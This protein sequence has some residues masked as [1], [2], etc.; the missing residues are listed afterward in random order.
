MV[1]VAEYVVLF[2]GANVTVMVQLPPAARLVPQVVVSVKGAVLPITIELIATAVEPELVIVID[3]DEIFEPAL[4]EPKAMLVALREIGEIPVPVSETDWEVP[5]AVNVSVP[6]EL[7]SAVGAKVTETVQLPAA[8]M[9]APH[10]F[11]R[12][13][14]APEVVSD[15]MASAEVELPLVMVTV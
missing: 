3:R 10:V 1:R 15:A 5:P 7:V 8:G 9:L 13:N 4:T 14:G 6:E 11:V 12:A 2:T